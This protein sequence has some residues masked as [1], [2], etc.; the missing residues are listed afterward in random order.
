MSSEITYYEVAKTAIQGQ[1]EN[2]SVNRVCEFHVTI[3]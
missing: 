2:P 1:N 3:L